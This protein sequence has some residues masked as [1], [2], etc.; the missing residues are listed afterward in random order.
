MHPEAEETRQAF[1]DKVFN[2][3]FISGI[4]RDTGTGW[5]VS[6]HDLKDQADLMERDENGLY[7]DPRISAIWYG[8]NL[9]LKQPE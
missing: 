9:A 8:W 4:K 6:R 3:Y 7:I 1:E 5:M 2:D